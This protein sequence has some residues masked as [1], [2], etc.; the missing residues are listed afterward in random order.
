[1]S[2]SVGK[3]RCQ[4]FIPYPARDKWPCDNVLVTILPGLLLPF[5]T[6]LSATRTGWGPACHFGWPRVGQ[7]TGK[8]QDAEFNLADP[9]PVLANLLRWLPR[10]V[11]TVSAGLAANTLRDPAVP[12]RVLWFSLEP[13]R[14]SSSKLRK[15]EVILPP[16][17]RQGISANP[18][19]PRS[20]AG[21]N[22]HTEGL[23]RRVFEKN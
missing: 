8:P 18:S 19:T 15:I 13:L 7:G 1:M 5:W 20:R 17:P 14:A 22:L 23:V 16:P 6:S 9:G 11:F 21:V 12:R 3:M 4:L 10:A 2:A